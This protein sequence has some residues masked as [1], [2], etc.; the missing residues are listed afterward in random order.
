MKALFVETGIE[1]RILTDQ[2]IKDYFKT[3]I[4][5]SVVNDNELENFAK[6]IKIPLIYLEP[7]TDK[8]T[9]LIHY[10]VQIQKIRLKKKLKSK[11]SIKQSNKFRIF[12]FLPDLALTI[13]FKAL[14]FIHK[15][16]NRNKFWKGLQVTI[17]KYNLEEFIFAGHTGDIKELVSVTAH[18]KNVVT[19]VIQNSWKDL[20]INPYL[21]IH[22]DKMMVW[23]DEIAQIYSNLNPQQKQISWSIGWHPRLV[24]LC[25]YVPDEA[26]DNNPT[27]ILYTCANPRIIPYE[28]QLLELIIS[29]VLSDDKSA[30]FIVRP[31]PQDKEP[32]RWNNLA[33][34]FERCKISLTG[35]YWND[36]TKI[37]VAPS[38]SECQW[39]NLL[40][41][42]TLVMN[43]AS[44][45]TI[46][47]LLLKKNVI[48][49]TFG[50]DGNPSESLIYQTKLPYYEGLLNHP[51]VFICDRIIDL[52]KTIAKALA[53]PFTE[54]PAEHFLIKTN[55]L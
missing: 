25:T 29:N 22:V 28:M 13:L 8:S 24:K 27:I 36:Q 55:N 47:A 52:N 6:K 48:N 53:T 40:Q 33:S 3:G 30:I 32:T 44:T 43:I 35:W 50:I 14:H 54:I 16:P 1:L 45:V 15:Y 19:Y 34:N 12:E 9:R 37:N 21:Q 23:S 49:I 31:N 17:E 18:K 10:I 20:F 42:C 51:N 5:V 39:N 41:E 7:P 38:E 4:I 11:T 46:E 2:F 26:K